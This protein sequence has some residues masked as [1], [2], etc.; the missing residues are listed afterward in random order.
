M[1]DIDFE[2]GND[3]ISEAFYKI[4]NHMK[5]LDNC[6]DFRDDI[7]LLENRNKSN[8]RAF[9]ITETISNEQYKIEK[10]RII[11][12]LQLIVH[13]INVVN[14]ERLNVFETFIEVVNDIQFSRINDASRFYSGHKASWNDIYS[15]YDIQRDITK[16]IKDLINNLLEKRSPSYI[17]IIGLSGTGKSTMLKRL[18][19]DLINENIKVINVRKDLIATKLNFLKEIIRFQEVTTEKTVV[20]IDDFSDLFPTPS[21]INEIFSEIDA[22]LSTL[23]IPFIFIFSEQTLRWHN[24]HKSLYFLSSNNNFFPFIIQK[25]KIDEFNRLSNKLS[26]L[27][28]INNSLEIKTMLHSEELNFDKELLIVLYELRYGSLFD[29]IIQREFDRILKDNVKRLYANIC[30]FQ[31]LGLPLDIYIVDDAYKSNEI[32][33][34]LSFEPNSLVHL[35]EITGSIFCR[36][37]IIANVVVKYKYHSLSEVLK[38]LG[39]MINN[40]VLTKNSHLQYFDRIIFDKSIRVKILELFDSTNY[41]IFI[42]QFVEN[43]AFSFKYN[44]HL[45]AKFLSFLGMLLKQVNLINEAYTYFNAAI[46]E[47][48]KYNFAYRQIAWIEHELSKWNE[49]EQHITYSVSLDDNN[50]L[51]NYYAA[52]IMSLHTIR[53]FYDADKYFAKAIRL[54]P[55]NFELKKHYKNYK[56]AESVISNNLE[57]VD[58]D[59]IPVR[60]ICNMDPGLE[61]LA[62]KYG[63]NSNYFKNEV[64]SIINSVELDQSYAG[65]EVGNNSLILLN[66][67]LKSGEDKKLKAKILSHFAR[68]SYEKYFYHKIE[69]EFAEVEEQFKESI[70]L[71]DK[72]AISLCYY[73]TFLKEIK[74][75]N[76]EALKYYKLSYELDA[77]NLRV[78]NDYALF[79]IDN[80]IWDNQRKGDILLAKSLL[81]TAVKIINNNKS[82][83]YW[84]I[85]NLQYCMTL[86]K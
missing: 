34:L 8:E 59:D 36:H 50:F 63:I 35:N 37:N 48:V 80:Y 73:G 58:D 81:E 38:D 84:P 52:R 47:D 56:R 14:G 79:L 69:I 4:L 1:L 23:G 45:K 57:L 21:D 70:R 31:I 17:S 20:L 55:N 28:L 44:H 74:K 6:P 41:Q 12:G 16:D 61:F 33:D 2:I 10:N 85:Y 66:E 51:N 86:I 64:R 46:K 76:D 82:R 5:N 19:F 83:F 75:D 43:A 25:L 24:L 9:K 78:L 54:K 26:N 39:W 18:G 60:L 71:N 40:L 67:Y 65:Y 49:S 27:K 68:H 7:I 42:R 62:N 72:D 11:N 77:T 29:N 13:D 30:L 22:E 32:Q 3:K 53:S 15:Q